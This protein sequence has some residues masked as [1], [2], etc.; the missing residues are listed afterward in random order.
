METNLTFD[1]PLMRRSELIKFGIPP[2]ILDEAFRDRGQRFAYKM[3]P[4]KS[5]S[6]IVFE[7]AGFIRWLCKRANLEAYCRELHMHA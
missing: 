4:S 1:K 6:P 7:T 2:T 5:N 3:N